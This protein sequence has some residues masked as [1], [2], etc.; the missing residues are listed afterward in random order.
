MN[1]TFCPKQI[2]GGHCVPSRPWTEANLTSLG[3]VTVECP[4]LF[5]LHVS[6]FYV[7]Q[8]FGK[9]IIESSCG[10]VGQWPHGGLGSR[11]ARFN[12]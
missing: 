4:L 9:L 8:C 10:T 3:K 5:F 1:F 7:Q 12:F 2:L 6:C 11:A